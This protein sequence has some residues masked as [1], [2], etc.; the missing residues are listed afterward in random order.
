MLVSQFNDLPETEA[1]AVVEVWAAVPA[2]RD[3][4]VAGRPYPDADGVLAAADA[5]ARRWTA[6]DLE[7]AL[8]H[9]PRIGERPTGSGA[10]ASASRREQS[11]MNSAAP[12]TAEA[13][14]E[15]NRAYEERF[16]RV[17][18]I[19]AAGRT[20]DEILAELRRRLDADDETETATALDELRQIAIL[21]ARS[22]FA[23]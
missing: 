12:S 22:T 21:R 5:A 17:F 18:L 8:A 3:A 19:R 7:T 10:E 2:W 9:H 1:E 15:G 6:T 13:I 14:A 11:A 20:P 16:G 23:D 4:I